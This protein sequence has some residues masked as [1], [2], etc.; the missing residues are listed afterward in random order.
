MKSNISRVEF[1]TLSKNHNSVGISTVQ[2]PFAQKNTAKK[3]KGLIKDRSYPDITSL[4]EKILATY[5][6]IKNNTI[7]KIIFRYRLNFYN[8]DIVKNMK[9]EVLKINKRYKLG[10][11]LCCIERYN[12]DSK[13]IYVSSSNHATK[14]EF[15]FVFDKLTGELILFTKNKDTKCRVKDGQIVHSSKISTIENAKEASDY[16]CIRT[17]T[18]LDGNLLSKTE[19]KPVPCYAE[20][21]VNEYNSKGKNYK[22]GLAEHDGLGGTHIERSFV[23]LDGTKTDYVY[24]DD[25]V[26]RFL[27]YKITDKNGKILYENSK[28]FKELEPNRYISTNNNESYDIQFFE[29]RVEITK[30]DK[31]NNMT[32]KKVTYNIKEYTKEEYNFYETIAKETDIINS[33]FHIKDYIDA[34]RE[35]NAIDIHTV[36]KNLLPFL[37]QLSGEEWFLL[38]DRNVEFIR[39]NNNDIDNAFSLEGGI[40]IGENTD[41]LSS[42][43]H[44]IGHEIL[45]DLLNDETCLEIFNEEKD[46]CNK[47]LPSVELEQIDYLINNKSSKTRSCS[48]TIAEINKI[49]NKPED[50]I[51]VGPRATYIMKYFPKTIAYVGRYRQKIL[52]RI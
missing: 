42:L 5:M 27:Y 44:E 12:S 9:K 31:H 34:Y 24:A 30:L 19:I 51:G 22:V 11:D 3:T 28:K 21:E 40:E 32:N 16:G 14:D 52:Q 37:K 45:K 18:D 2:I 46:L 8:K 48:E 1:N 7:G 4:K 29:N 41:A 39:R 17:I 49:L 10:Y 35:N 47:F 43:E 15:F 38:Q 13:Y 6:N 36:D 25:K 26:N 33:I 23:S 50:L 20:Y